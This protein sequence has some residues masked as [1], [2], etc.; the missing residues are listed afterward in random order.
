MLELLLLGYFEGIESVRVDYIVED[1][2]K[3][4]VSN[5]P[6]VRGRRDVITQR[7]RFPILLEF[8]GNNEVG[9]CLAEDVEKKAFNAWNEGKD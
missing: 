6:E 7:F 3:V 4:V 8:M 9:I 2:D 5:I 1:A